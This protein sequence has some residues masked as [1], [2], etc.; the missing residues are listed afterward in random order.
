[1]PAERVTLR[2]L[3]PGDLMALQ[4]YRNDPEVGR[5]QGW[6][7]MTDAAAAAMITEMAAASCPTPG[8]WVQIAIADAA[9]DELLGDI[10]LHVS[11]SGEEAELGITLA[12][13]AQGRG[14]A[15]EAARALIGMLREYTQVRRLVGI[16]DV[17]NT[18][19]A[20]LL[21][22]LGMRFEAEE[23][24]IFRGQP[25]VEARYALAL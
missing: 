17:Q 22:R 20:R 23:E 4:A 13:S 25:C 7:P 3:R 24:I 12:P 16:T 11:A 9:T 19:S 15:A 6:E 2:R 5:Y 18:A 21:E 8:D 14:L 1:M 10:G